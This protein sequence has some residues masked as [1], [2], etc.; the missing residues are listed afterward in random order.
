MYG[1]IKT[2]LFSM[3]ADVYSQLTDQDENTGEIKRRWVT[4]KTIPCLVIPIRESGGSATSDNKVFD[5]QY[6]EELEVKLHTNEKLNK[7]WRVSSIKNVKGIPLYTEIDRI[8]NPDTIFEVY[9]SH[10]IFDIFG[11]VN[12]YENHLKRVQ[13]QLND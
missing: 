4:L 5:K 7:R 13:V 2:S 9:A 10:P 11:N 6:I 12:Y 3:T 1:C 8:S